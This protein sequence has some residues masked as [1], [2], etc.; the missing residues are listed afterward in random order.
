MLLTSQVLVHHIR[1]MFH[2]ETEHGGATRPT[3]QPEQDRSF[4]CV[5]L[6]VTVGHTE[7]SQ[8]HPVVSLLNRTVKKEINHTLLGQCYVI[9]QLPNQHQ[10]AQE[11]LL[12][13]GHEDPQHCLG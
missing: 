12:P 6:S 2:K 8:H 10:E 4:I 13:S 7:R 9:T 1:S 11:E 5:R 3:L